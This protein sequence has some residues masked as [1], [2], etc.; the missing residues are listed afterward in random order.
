[1]RNPHVIE[2]TERATRTPSAGAVTAVLAALVVLDLVLSAWGFLFPGA[3]YR[4]FHASPYV[5]PQGLLPRCAAN[6]LAFLAIQVLAL[7]R[8]RHW[9]GWLLLVAGCRLGDCVTDLSCLAFCESATT[10]ARL[11]FPAAGLGNLVVGLW[12]VR[13]AR[14]AGE[15]AEQGRPPGAAGG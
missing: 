4:V 5:D 13:T 9:R 3:W 6:W 11:A 8:W 10:L 15:A 7:A 14:R 2:P 12:L 1:M